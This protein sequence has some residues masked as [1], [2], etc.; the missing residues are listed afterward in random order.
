MNNLTKEESKALRMLIVN[1]IN[2]VNYDMNKHNEKELSEE[3]KILKSLWKK[4]SS[5]TP[6]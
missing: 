6:F 2:E 5:V 3:L 1:E 4:F